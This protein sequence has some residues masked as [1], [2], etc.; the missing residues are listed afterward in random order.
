MSLK[1][2]TITG[3]KWSFVDSFANQG[4]QLIIGIILAR[5]LSPREFGLIGI[6][7]AFIALSQSFVDSG[8][9]QTLIRKNNCT[10]ADYCTV[11]YFNILIGL[12][13]YAVLFFLV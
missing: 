5:L 11:F 12:L 3:L 1:N 10:Q 6:I 7:T 13:F 9:S 2:K 8:F 4:V